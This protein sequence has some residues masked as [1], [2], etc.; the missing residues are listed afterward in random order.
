MKFGLRQKVTNDTNQPN[1]ICKWLIRDSKKKK[2]A[3]SCQFELL[4]GQT[5]EL[6]N[7]VY[8]PYTF[9][10]A[11]QHVGLPPSFGWFTLEK[12]KLL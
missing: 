3:Q 1:I 9:N 10:A 2:M 11:A 7:S 4:S 6:K 8:I 12:A 5:G